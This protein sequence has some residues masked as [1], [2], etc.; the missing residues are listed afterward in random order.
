M[1]SQEL[2]TDFVSKLET[3]YLKDVNLKDSW[4]YEGPILEK[5]FG[6]VADEISFN[7]NL[8]EPI[9]IG[10]GGV[11]ALV[12]DRNLETNRALKVSRPSQGKERL[13]ASILVKET[14]SLKRLS[15]T[16]L[17]K[18]FAQGAVRIGEISRTNDDIGRE[19]KVKET[20]SSVSNVG[21]VEGIDADLFPY[22]VMEFI[23]GVKDSDQFLAHKGIKQNDVLRIFAGVIS[24]VKYMHDQDTIHMDLKPGNIFVTPDGTPIIIDLGFAKHLKVGNSL[25]LIGGTE[26]FLHPDA[27]KFIRDLSKD[28]NRLRGEAAYNNINKTWDLFSLGKTFLALL[29]VLDQHNPKALS[30][31]TRRY[32]RLMSCRLLDGNNTHDERAIGLSIST[33]REIKYLNAGQLQTDIEKLTGIYNLAVRI[34]ELNLHIQDTIQTSTLAITPFTER[35]A[36]LLAHP[37]L[38]RLGNCTQL[39]LLNLVYPTATHTRLEHSI[40]TYS[41]LCRFILALYNDPL[42]PLFCQIMDENDLRS[43]L[44]ASLLHDIGQYALAHDLEE[45]DNTFFSH[46]KLGETL[47]KKEGNSLGKLIERVDGWNVSPKRIISILGA[48]PTAYQS[49]LKDRI[50]R[51]LI[52]GPIDADKIDYLMRDSQALGLTYGRAMDFER[53]LRCLTIVSKEKEDGETFAVLGIHEKGKI[54]SEGIAFARY[55]MFGQVYWHHTYRAIKSM[56]HRMVWEMLSKLKGN[57]NALRARFRSFITEEDILGNGGQPRLPS[58]EE[59]ARGNKSIIQREDLAVLRWIANESGRGGKQ[60]L[61]LLEKRQLFKRVLV[62]SHD[63]AEDKELWTKMTRFY[64]TPSWRK[65][66]KLQTIFQEKIVSLVENPPSEEIPLTDV[67][68]PDAK[69]NFIADGKEFIILLID[70]PPVRQSSDV[71]LMYLIEEDR[72]RIKIDENQV[73]TVEESVVWDALQM[74]FQESIGKLRVFCHPDHYRFLSAYLSRAVIESALSSSLDATLDSDSDEDD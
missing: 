74:K 46:S 28:P 73:G 65:K 59:N 50:L 48:R 56:I 14:H 26:G 39:G 16:N 42:N 37:S 10:G 34:P 2:P 52:N 7:Y 60:F 41:V 23:D 17:I 72:R 1:P 57:I 9:N 45:A 15:H 31:Y 71:P 11:V 49:A 40:G 24:A 36:E 4:E 47:L 5:I 12:Y 68:T 43:A 33:L 51:S 20:D 55:A 35:L 25:T 69:N 8:I 62:L 32:L 19:N 63:R 27:R 44:L 29:K 3:K 64:A 6:K 13:L 70:L 21:K 58:F 67:I 18:I 61:D 53:L 54:P 66:L 22:Y 38:M 30:P